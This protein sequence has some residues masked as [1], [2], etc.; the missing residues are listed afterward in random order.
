MTS[1]G[2]SIEASGVRPAKPTHLLLELINVLLLND[3]VLDAAD[4]ATLLLLCRCSV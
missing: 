2:A 3:G 4:Q 1:N